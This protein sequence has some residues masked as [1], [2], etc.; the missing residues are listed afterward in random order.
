MLLS[1]PC[2]ALL[3]GRTAT[4]ACI[5]SATMPTAA[6]RTVT[7]SVR[8]S[9]RRLPTPRGRGFSVLDS[10]G[11][12]FGRGATPVPESAQVRLVLCS[13]CSYTPSVCGG[14]RYLAIFVVCTRKL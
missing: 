11:A 9:V 1:A 6:M 8:R 5:G 14:R 7:A 12:V 13:A 4:A 3:G 2:V 10:V